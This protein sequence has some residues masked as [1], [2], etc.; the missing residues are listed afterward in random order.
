MTPAAQ[1]M[2][3]SIHLIAREALSERKRIGLLLKHLHRSSAAF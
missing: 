3:M 1:L 2:K